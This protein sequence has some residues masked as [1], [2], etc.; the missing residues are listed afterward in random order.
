MAERV[1]RQLIDDLDGTDI[2]DGQG[3]SVEFS[4]RDTKYRIDL[5]SQNISKLERA[6]SPYIKAAATVSG[7]RKRISTPTKTRSSRRRRP[8]KATQSDIRAWATENGFEVSGKGRIA[9]AV[10]EAYEAARKG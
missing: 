1:I 10:V 7:P 9:A 6:L 8:A 2:T 5:S 3:E 4:L